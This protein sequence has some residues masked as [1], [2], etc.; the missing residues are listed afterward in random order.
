MTK[1][2]GL[3]LSCNTAKE[4]QSPFYDLATLGC[5]TVFAVFKKTP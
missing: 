5:C 4:R 2:V 3:S 1:L